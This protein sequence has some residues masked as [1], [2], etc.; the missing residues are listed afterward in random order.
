MLPDEGR[1][2]GVAWEMLRS[3]T[4]AFCNGYFFEDDAAQTSL[5]ALVEP[6]RR[7]ALEVSPQR[8]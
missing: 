3:G 1:Y 5:L 6:E 8:P 4:T 7:E 2:A